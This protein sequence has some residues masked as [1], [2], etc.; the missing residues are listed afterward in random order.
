[1]RNIVVDAEHGSLVQTKREV[2]LDSDR[3]VIDFLSP[4]E[5]RIHSFVSPTMTTTPSTP[6]LSLFRRLLFASHQDL[7][8]LQPLAYR[9]SWFPGVSIVG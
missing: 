9:Q 3:H 8:Q 2:H 5:F 4:S 6:L 1:V 7:Q